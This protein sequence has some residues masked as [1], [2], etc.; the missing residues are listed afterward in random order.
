MRKFRVVAEFGIADHEDAMFLL[1]LFENA[2]YN[3]FAGTAIAIGKI[4]IT[5]V[6][7]EPAL[8]DMESLKEVVRFAA[9]AMVFLREILGDNA[10]RTFAEL[11]AEYE[12]V[13][14]SPNLDESYGAWVEMRA[15]EILEKVLKPDG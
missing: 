15:A 10:D 4:S 7:E 1:P 8:P 9:D 13:R 14:D 5:P 3:R 11:K 6:N 2:V 12:K